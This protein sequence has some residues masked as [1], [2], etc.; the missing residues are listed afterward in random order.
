MD[1]DELE[2]ELAE[3]EELEAD[4]LLNDLPAMTNVRQDTMDEYAL[5]A[6]PSNRINVSNNDD[7]ELA[8]LEAMM[9]GDYIDDSSK[10]VSLGV[11]Q[12]VNHFQGF[13]FERPKKTKSSVIDLF[14]DVSSIQN[15]NKD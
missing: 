8:E 1:D 5:P 10:M 13:T 2:E 15:N 6:A 14:G 12:D 3:L 7:D 9:D 11:S 4:E